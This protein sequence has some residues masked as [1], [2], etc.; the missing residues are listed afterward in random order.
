ME[1]NNDENSNKDHSGNESSVLNDS[2]NDNNI[3]DNNKCSDSINNM[4]IS[5]DKENYLYLSD[6]DH[7]S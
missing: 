6:D 1:N 4:D 5:S 7:I 2:I 3:K